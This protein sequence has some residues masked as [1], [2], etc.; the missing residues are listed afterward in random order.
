MTIVICHWYCHESGVN[1]SPTSYDNSNL[2]LYCHER[3]Q[4][5]FF[6]NQMRNFSAMPWRERLKFD[7]MMIRFVLN[8]HV[9]WNFIVLAH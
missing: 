4:V 9:S 5:M 3:E 6:L 2:S 1:Q 8:Q 7:A